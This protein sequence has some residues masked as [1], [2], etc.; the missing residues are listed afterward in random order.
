MEKNNPIV[1]YKKVNV[2][3]QKVIHDVQ[4]GYKASFKVL[5]RENPLSSL[6]SIV[7]AGNIPE[8]PAGTYMVID[9]DWDTRSR[10]GRLVNYTIYV[11]DVNGKPHR[12]IG[13]LE[14]N[15]PDF[16]L[17]TFVNMV[18]FHKRSG[19]LWKEVV[20]VYKNPYEVCSFEEADSIFKETGRKKNDPI[21]LNALLRELVSK[22]RKCR[23]DH[24]TVLEFIKFLEK[25][26]LQ[27]SYSPL[28]VIQKAD[29]MESDAFYLK[30]NPEK[31]EPC[32]YDA[33][34]YRAS[35]YIKRDMEKRG[36]LQTE[37]LQESQIAGFMPVDELDEDQMAALMCLK[38]TKP[39]AIA[40]GAG[41]GKTTEIMTVI[42]C[43]TENHPDASIGLFAPTGRASRRLESVTGWNAYTIH[44]GVGKLID[45]DFA[46]FNEYNKLPCSL[47][48]V[49]ESSM[50]DTL[51]MYDLLR[52][53][54]EDA[55]IIFVGDH[56]QLYPV[57]VG[58]PFFTFM[59]E[60]LCDVFYL[61][62]NHRQNNE[63]IKRN[64]DLALA[65]KP[66]VDGGH[67]VVRDVPW[68]ELPKLLKD[69]TDAGGEMASPSKLQIISP[70]TKMN[71]YINNILRKNGEVTRRQFSIGD[72]VIA[73]KN[74]DD[75]CNGD[76]GYVM[77]IT[78]NCIFVQFE[79]GRRICVENSLLDDIRLAYSITV[80]KMQGSESSKVF[81]FLPKDENRFIDKRLLYT[82]VTRAKDELSIYYYRE[83]DDFTALTSAS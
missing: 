28:S 83:N 48:I 78:D 65:G 52:A 67:V 6:S 69:I 41:S 72:K 63:D 29:L 9:F 47:V 20:R 19:F 13:I 82:G 44:R 58:E 66:F 55:K 24:L 45:T 15:I 22:A 18:D 51:L 39:S 3:V 49:D 11:G 26:E 40:G 59:E 21:R 32:F 33:E 42:Q 14:K 64:A 71:D 50:I 79:D 76:I 43:Y 46:A 54:R 31:G 57:G 73:I 2:I 12:N 70:F 4:N 68:S 38:T 56:N 80:H 75:Y 10:K 8:M 77:D 30:E 37:F 1:T 35:E 25:I 36:I 61:R 23:K 27:G 5:N 7:I 17:D 62:Q 81:L 16:C 34:I 60:N 53:I 74:R